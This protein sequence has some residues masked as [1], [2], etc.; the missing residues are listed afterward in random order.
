MDLSPLLRALRGGTLAEYEEALGAFDVKAM[1]P[2]DADLLLLDLLEMCRQD[3]LNDKAV[4]TLARWESIV[5]DSTDYDP[6]DPQKGDVPTA[7]LIRLFSLAPA[8]PETLAYVGWLF[9]EVASS[10]ELALDVCERL[11]GPQTQRALETIFR[12]FGRPGREDLIALRG[13][14]LEAQNPQAREYVETAL[15]EVSP[16][17]PAPLW[18]G[19]FTDDEE[20]PLQSEIVYPAPLGLGDVKEIWPPT[21]AADYA[22]AGAAY[23]GVQPNRAGLLAKYEKL[24]AEAP[25]EY[26][27]EVGLFALAEMRSA[28]QEDPELFRIFG[29]CNTRLG[30][31][32]SADHPCASHGGC[33]M[34]LCQCSEAWDDDEE[35]DSGLYAADRAGGFRLMAWFRGSCDFCFRR[36]ASPYHALRRPL[37][38]GGW[39]GTFCSGECLRDFVQAGL[40]RV[41]G[42]QC[43]EGRCVPL[44]NDDP[45]VVVVRL[46]EEE[47]M[48]TGIQDRLLG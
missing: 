1:P 10:V 45:E 25:E 6:Y 35:D 40:R 29:P 14:A 2:G 28:L 8:D 7:A 32:L 5:W 9:A 18:L 38:A 39:Q 41:D 12:T 22:S 19:N 24:R 30:C 17:A 43:A 48:A 42:A 11:A 13:V 31:D 36:I 4:A 44:A 27:K 21:K 47:V 46:L 33:R 16:F 37:L 23:F 34:F 15:R 20:L 3:G 26:K